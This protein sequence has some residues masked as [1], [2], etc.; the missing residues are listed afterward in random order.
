MGARG[1]RKGNGELL[2]TKYSLS[3]RDEMVLEICC[4]TT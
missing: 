1:W 3:L 2:L 4:T